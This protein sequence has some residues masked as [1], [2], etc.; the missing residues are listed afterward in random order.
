MK[1]S[2]RERAHVELL[3]RCVRSCGSSRE[4]ERVRAYVE[5]L[6]GIRA[7]EAMHPMQQPSH[8]FFPGLP[9]NPWYEPEE[10]PW[11]RKLVE[12]YDQIREEAD[13]ATALAA[14]AP[15][16]GP[17]AEG[18]WNVLHL[19]VMG[20]PTA[21]GRLVCPKTSGFVTQLPGCGDAGMVYISSLAPGTHVKAHCGASNTRLRC[22]LG[23]K[24]PPSCSIR[25]GDETRDW[26]ECGVLV[27][28]DSID[29]EVWNRGTETR[30]VLILD[31]WHPDLTPAERKALVR[32][33][34][35]RKKERQLRRNTLQGAD[36]VARDAR[37]LL[38]AV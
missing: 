19:R 22:H 38:A 33:S 24:V 26:R 8:G 28:D 37:R 36:R 25:V 20:Q 13:R 23:L 18:T 6:C 31:F 10:F 32:L 2:F 21:A 3:W 30:Q 9:T 35:I 27:F 11:T 14:H 15:Q 17:L 29:H 7:L 16:I 34:Y 4:M 1:I 5:S 12:E